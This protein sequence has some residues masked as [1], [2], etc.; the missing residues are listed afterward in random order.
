VGLEYAVDPF[1]LSFP[2]PQNMDPRQCDYRV[3]LNSSCPAHSY[4]LG[5]YYTS[6]AVGFLAILV[7]LGSVGIRVGLGFYLP[8]FP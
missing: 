1:F 8:F 4:Y 6:I 2:T 3:A 5:F 7:F